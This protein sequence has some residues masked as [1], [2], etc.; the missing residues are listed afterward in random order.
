MKHNIS[1]LFIMLILSSICSAYTLIDID[2]DTGRIPMGDKIYI[3]EDRERV[4]II[5][6]IVQKDI[7]TDF[8][9][10]DQPSLSLGFTG[11]TYWFA[12]II[13]N[14]T[15]KET[16]FLLEIAYPLLNY[17]ALYSFSDG[18][19]SAKETG[20]LF[21]FYEREFEHRNFVFPIVLK[22]GIN[23][24]YLKC[25]TESSMDLPIYLWSYDAFQANERAE[26]PIWWLYFGLLL[27]MIVY[28]ILIF[29][30]IKDAKYL[31][32]SLFIFGS[33]FFQFSLSGLSFQ[34]LWPDQLYW[35]THNIPFFIC[36]AIFWGTMF[37][38]FYLDTK[39]ILPYW[40]RIANY[41]MIAYLSWLFVGLVLPYR[42]SISIAA[43]FS[44]IFVSSVFYAGFIYLI[45]KVKHARFFILA[46][47]AFF[48]GV[49]LVV[50]KTF[51]IMPGGFLSKW[52]FQ[53]GITI[54]VL[55]LSLGLADKVNF[56]NK[57]LDDL[58][59]NLEEKVNIRTMEIKNYANTL[60]N[61]MDNTGEGFLTFYD[62]LIINKN[63][64]LECESI[65]KT[66]IEDKYFPELLYP[67]SEQEAQFLDRLLK[68][69]FHT[70]EEIKK[71]ALL[72]LLPSEAFINNMY[73][74]L[75]FKAIE[76]KG[77]Q[78]I[79]VILVDATEKH[80]LEIQM[81]TERNTLRMIVKILSDHD[82]FFDI[83][84]DYKDF[85]S[86]LIY[87]FVDDPKRTFHENMINIYRII[88]TF[89]GSFSQYNMQGAVD[90]LHGFETKLSEFCQD[91]ENKTKEDAIA[92][93]RDEDLLNSLQKDFEIINNILGRNFFF[94]ENMINIEK[95]KLKEIESKVSSIF[96]PEEIK[97]ML[98]EIKKLRYKTLKNLLKPYQEYVLMSGEKFE[99]HVKFE[100]ITGSDVL[101]DPD[102][103]SGFIK[104]LVHVFRNSIDHGI[105]YPEER[106]SLG[107]DESG[108]ISCH[109]SQK[110]NT[111]IISVKDDGRG[112]NA[113]EIAEKII[114]RGLLSPEDIN[115]LSDE[116]I[117]DYI[118]TDEFSSKED[119]S[120][121]SGRGI[122]L[123]AVRGELC[124][125]NGRYEI[126]SISGKGTEFLFYLPFI[127]HSDFI[128]I[129][130]KK[131]MYSFLKSLR[132]NMKDIAD[133]ITSDISSPSLIEK[134]M[135]DLKDITASINVKNTTF[136]FTII[137]SMDNSFIKKLS[138]KYITEDEIM[139]DD[140]IILKEV[141]KEELNIITGNTNGI[142]K[143]ANCILSIAPPEIISDLSFLNETIIYDC[144][145]FNINVNDSNISV[146]FIINKPV[147][148]PGDK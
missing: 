113:Q 16:E 48:L 84:N 106:R 119:I 143:D 138:K 65:F 111:L 47:I 17:L 115:Y 86:E 46:W 61:I 76:H 94:K 127:E 22:P 44:F 95:N 130:I 73:I 79:M 35:V 19:Y 69:I 12:F 145:A 57:E 117:I 56:L 137:F 133:I 6:D 28:N 8:Y 91:I 139:N 30:S 134:D 3:L 110:N 5:D 45:K 24:F 146:Y 13:N 49:L 140:D 41:L 33:S 142:L 39:V 55:F 131:V 11:S 71:D 126:K 34:Y 103:Y 98:P 23:N 10:S 105:E 38:K 129:K 85:V 109:I 15:G 66:N 59:K 50:L 102:N 25:R 89:K 93:I 116:E 4:F 90:E 124:K 136:E 2:P 53:V 125:L 128:N 26:N 60:K 37:S 100:S 27:T 42:I 112:I 29:I 21:P 132:S 36:F 75:K 114:K 52:G 108:N 54:N 87:E 18:S 120:D 107:K 80:N 141:L 77:R 58:N 7:E 67:F 72:S 88:H 43:I 135:I 96:P 51:G 32:Y 101:V 62:D 20:T 64:S 122:G 63:Y 1:I 121:F 70:K 123:G 148:S 83:Y 82:A 40:D 99:K 81:E 147:N 118:F 68:K 9:L 14:N 104:S 78:M 144:W 92:L 31:Y 97:I 74:N